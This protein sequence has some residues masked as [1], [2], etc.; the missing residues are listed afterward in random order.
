VERVFNIITRKLKTIAENP[1]RKSLFS[2]RKAISALFPYAIHLEGVGWQEAADV[3]AHLFRDSGIPWCQI[4]PYVKMWFMKSTSFPLNQALI[5]MLPC[6]DWHR[7]HYK[8][9]EK[10][11]K[12]VLQVSFTEEV[13]RSAVAVML[14]ISLN[15]SLWP[16]IPIN[17]WAWLKEQPALSPL[18]GR[19]PV[20]MD[21]G[22]IRYLHGLDDIEILKSYLLVLWSEGHEVW[23]LDEAADFICETFGGIGM[24]DHKKDLIKRL[25]H[26]LGQLDQ[27][28]AYSKQHNIWSLALGRQIWSRTSC[29]R[30][31]KKLLEGVDSDED[32]NL[33]V[34]SH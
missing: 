3:I 13:C 6:A 10:W 5:H 28:L 25:D 18:F 7:A 12:V 11:T 23:F 15:D 26:V 22:L 1:D 4:K 31:L 27:G 16:L 14:Q 20:K 34:V 2:K 21:E 24:Q 8:T 32:S 30:R 19:Q 29:Y 17:I 9:V 33:Y